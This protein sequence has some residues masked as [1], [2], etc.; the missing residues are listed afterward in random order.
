[1]G[2]LSLNTNVSTTDFTVAP[3]LTGPAAPAAPAA[4]TA[5]T[6]PTAATFTFDTISTAGGSTIVIVMDTNMGKPNLPGV[7]T[8]GKITD[9]S[10]WLPTIT[11]G[12][13]FNL[14]DIM[15]MIADAMSKMQASQAKIQ[16]EKDMA[17][18]LVERGKEHIQH[19]I[20]DAHNGKLTPEE[21]SELRHFCIS[22]G[23]PQYH[24]HHLSLAGRIREFFTHHEMFKEGRVH[25]EANEYKREVFKDSDS[26]LADLA[27]KLLSKMSFQTKT[28]LF[29][30]GD[31]ELHTH[32]HHHIAHTGDVPT[33]ANTPSTQSTSG[34]VQGDTSGTSAATTPAAPP[35]VGA[36]VMAP[37]TTP[38]TSTTSTTA[39]TTVTT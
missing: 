9:A 5:P 38:T 27:E 34:G 28:E 39:N 10:S 19:L 35:T 6:E 7:D 4:P 2:D 17:G 14:M 23:E 21:K 26:Q 18:L 30:E 37:V 8:D 32:P 15:L 25:M 12:G 11:K 20:D 36:P 3:G 29:K 24:H 33:N 13:H 1:M 22:A 31:E 16:A